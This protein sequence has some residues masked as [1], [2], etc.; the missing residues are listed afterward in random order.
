M[1]IGKKGFIENELVRLSQNGDITAYTLL[2]KEYSTGVL[3]F[4]NRLVSS[5]EDAED[6]SS[7]ELINFQW[8][9]WIGLAGLIYSVF[10]FS[11]FSDG[12]R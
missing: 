2:V 12:R 8:L 6:I 10:L 4:V 3:T 7:I 5:K 11:S 1:D 9:F